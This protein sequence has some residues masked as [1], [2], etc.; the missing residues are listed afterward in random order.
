MWITKLL[1]EQLGG[2]IGVE[3]I[4]GVGTHV[5]MRFKKR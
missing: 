4:K 3:S 2:T 1:V 5:V